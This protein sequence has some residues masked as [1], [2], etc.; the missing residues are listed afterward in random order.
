VVGPCA[1]RTPLPRKGAGRAARYSA[2]Y[3]CEAREEQRRTTATWT[4]GV[5]G[6]PG[7]TRPGSLSKPI[8]ASGPFGCDV[9]A[10]P[11]A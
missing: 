9:P 11:R 5:N 6:G 1:D 2:Q 3:G 4:S 10:K 7:V 8:G